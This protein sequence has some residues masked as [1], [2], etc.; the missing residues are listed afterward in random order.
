M[1]PADRLRATQLEQYRL[2]A[3]R[4]APAV[5]WDYL[6]TLMNQGKLSQPE[7]LALLDMPRLT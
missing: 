2:K 7:A 3:E 4:M 6:V 1:T 5:A